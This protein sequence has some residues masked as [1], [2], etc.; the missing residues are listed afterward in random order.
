MILCSVSFLPWDGRQ[1][2]IVIG[3]SNIPHRKQNHPAYVSVR[4]WR[5]CPAFLQESCVCAVPAASL[6]EVSSY[7][8]PSPT[9]Y[10][11]CLPKPY[12][13]GAFHP[14][15]FLQSFSLLFC[16]ALSPQWRAFNEQIPLSLS[17]CNIW[18]W[19][20]IYV[21][22]YCRRKRLFKLIILSFTSQM[23]FSLLGLP[24]IP[25]PLLP[26][27]S[28]PPPNPILVPWA[29]TSPQH[30]VRSHPLSLKQTRQPSATYVPGA[31]GQPMDVLWLLA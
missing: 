13:L 26:L 6:W 28:Y 14:N 4:T 9:S 21:P 20:S 15:C 16:R 7:G 10:K 11:C 23:L 24:S 8:C 29:I 3:F 25:S 27:R 22:I 5:Q 19:V 17:M 18:L 1:C 30:S 12:F 2:P 31:I